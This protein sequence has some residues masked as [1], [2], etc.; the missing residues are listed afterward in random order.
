MKI[1]KPSPSMVVSMIALFVALSGTAA[2]VTVSFARNAGAVDSRSAVSASAT[3]SGAAGKL[4]ATASKGA[5]AGKIP[6]KF[7]DGVIRGN[8]SLG[9]F[10]KGSA[11]IDNGTEIP[12]AIATTAGVGTISVSCGDQ[13]NTAGKVD[14]QNTSGTSANFRSPSG[15]TV[16]APNAQAS[17]AINGTSSYQVQAAANGKTIVVFGVAQQSGQNTAAGACTNYGLIVTID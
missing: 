2:A 6:S 14:P 17:F 15:I 5:S 11:V 13:N 16:V 8:G 12:S 4:V 9:Q 3:N 1:S 10:G 7:L